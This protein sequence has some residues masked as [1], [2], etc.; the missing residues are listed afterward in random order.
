MYNVMDFSITCEVD[1]VL[2]TQATTKNMCIQIMLIEFIALYC[3]QRHS[4]MEHGRGMFSALCTLRKKLVNEFPT[5]QKRT[6]HIARYFASSS[7]FFYLGRGQCHPLAL[8]V[9]SQAHENFLHPCRWLC[10]WRDEAQ[11]HRTHLPT[12]F[13]RCTDSG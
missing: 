3:G 11:A 6:E 4:L 8:E 5:I 1:M 2:Y 9:H 13:C 10:R 12:I 7:G